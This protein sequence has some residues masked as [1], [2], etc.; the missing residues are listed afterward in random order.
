[1]HD[2]ESLEAAWKRYHFKRRILPAIL[3]AVGIVVAGGAYWLIP[4][5]KPKKV[6][7]P[8]AITVP[9]RIKPDQKPNVLPPI[10]EKHPSPKAT[11]KA[12]VVKTEKR[13]P[14]H[15]TPV[16]ERPAKDENPPAKVAK[17]EPDMDFLQRF[18]RRPNRHSPAPKALPTP[19]PPKPQPII[20]EDAAPAKEQS[21][22][23]IQRKS[24]NKKLSIKSQKTNNTL[25]TLIERY[26]KT[27]DPKLATYIAQ[28]FY[29]KGN[30][31]ETIRWSIIANNLEPGNETSWLLFA[32]A[33][34]ALGQKEDAI[35]AL[36]IYLNQYSSK[37]IHSYLQTIEASA[38]H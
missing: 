32:K 23:V 33:K 4:D 38:W 9:V 5:E 14:A 24:P 37:K 17:I 36:R 16:I 20:R 29:K 13:P 21:R 1:M 15:S 3:T 19:K 28:S 8:S 2:I 35:N 31:K 12:T 25:K 11:T 26:N 34:V 22:T 27:E 30:Y 18:E 7:H 6:S 10:V